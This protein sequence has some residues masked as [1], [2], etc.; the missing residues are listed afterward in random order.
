MHLFRST[1]GVLLVGIFISGCSSVGSFRGQTTSTSI[2]LSQKNYRVVKTGARGE[3][4]GFW[5]LFIP[6]VSPTYAEAKEQLYR[7]VGVDLT[8]RAVALANQTEDK[9]SM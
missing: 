4:K 6:F 9:S 1:L 5:F 8:G 3:S 2:G 7:S